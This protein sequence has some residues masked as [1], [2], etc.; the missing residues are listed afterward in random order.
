MPGQCH[1]YAPQPSSR[2]PPMILWFLIRAFG[3][4]DFLLPLFHISLL[5][6][7]T[8]WDRDGLPAACPF[9]HR[10]YT[11]QG[12]NAVTRKKKKQGAGQQHAKCEHACPKLSL[13]NTSVLRKF[14]ESK[15]PQTCG[16]CDTC[17]YKN[18][19]RRAQSTRC[20]EQ[21]MSWTRLQLSEVGSGMVHEG[22][23]RPSGQAYPV[24][25]VPSA[26]LPAWLY[27]PIRC[28]AFSP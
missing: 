6:F 25:L 13:N 12:G 16:T 9:G 27:P 15:S 7:A 18:R 19:E 3:G 4:V 21:H 2:V 23:K 5:E 24:Y 22:T 26:W 20:K 17:R 8:I 11:R 1:L 10:H 28:L 14:N